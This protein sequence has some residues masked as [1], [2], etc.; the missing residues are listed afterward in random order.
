MMLPSAGAMCLQAWC[1]APSPPCTLGLSPNT[2][3]GAGTDWDPRPVPPTPSAPR[4]WGFVE[5][6]SPALTRG[7]IERGSADAGET[8]WAPSWW[9]FDPGTGILITAPRQ[10]GCGST[11]GLL[12]PC[13]AQCGDTGAWEATM[14]AAGLGKGWWLSPG[15][16]AGSRSCKPHQCLCHR[17][18][19]AKQGSSRGT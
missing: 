1:S 4:G 6:R 14:R 11:T 12:L 7:G 5:V 2:L 19:G 15:T 13:Y 10:H 16:A 8:P 3:C 18:R 17:A 9:L